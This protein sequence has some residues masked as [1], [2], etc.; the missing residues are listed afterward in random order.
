MF[1]ININGIRGK[2]LELQAYLS[3][4]NSDIVALQETKID[5]SQMNWYQGV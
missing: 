5:S 3:T 4:E 1:S 2:K